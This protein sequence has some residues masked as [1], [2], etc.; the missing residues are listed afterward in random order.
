MQVYFVAGLEYWRVPLAASLRA[1]FFAL[2]LVWLFRRLA[3]E[4]SPWTRPLWGVLFVVWTGW[5]TWTATIEVKIHAGF[6]AVLLSCYGYIWQRLF[7][8]E[9]RS[10]SVDAGVKWFESNPPL[11]PGLKCSLEG[12][13]LGVARLDESGAFLYFQSPEKFSA[14]I[15]DHRD[16]ELIFVRESDGQTVNVLGEAVRAVHPRKGGGGASADQIQGLGVR[17]VEADPDRLKSF[18]DFVEHMRGRGYGN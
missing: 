5:V 12:R 1:A 11:I 6:F 2:P 13:P 9:L 16:V 18:G 8:E 7:G 3:F 10:S 4:A 17:F 14:R 15:Y